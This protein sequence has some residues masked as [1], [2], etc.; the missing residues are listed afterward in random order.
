MS[1]TAHST[2]GYSGITMASGRARSEPASRLQDLLKNFAKHRDTTATIQLSKYRTLERLRDV[3]ASCSM[4]DWGGNE[5]RPI[6]ASTAEEAISLLEALPQQFS[7]AE[8]SPE[9]TGA[10]AF[11]WHFAPLRVAVFSLSG[12]GVIE[13]AILQGSTSEFHGRIP[14]VG[15]LPN[16]L[17]RHLVSVQGS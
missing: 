5:E 6:G 17:F 4:A 15:S 7:I 12:R 11:E 8:I 10:I 1:S 9:P 13:Y 14:F 3:V 2:S 16:I